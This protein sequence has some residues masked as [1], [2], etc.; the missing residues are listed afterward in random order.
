M[1]INILKGTR[2]YRLVKLKK[3]CE[4]TGDTP[5]SVHARRNKGVW[6][7]GKQTMLAP[8]GNLWVDLVEIEQ[9]VKHGN[10]VKH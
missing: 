3:Y 10:A 4:I 9:W 7:D 5:P 1:A 2:P 6:L 8:D